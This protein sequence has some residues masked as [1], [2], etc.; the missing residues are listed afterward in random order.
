MKFQKV[1]KPFWPTYS[2]CLIAAE[3]EHQVGWL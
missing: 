1:L 2:K 3:H